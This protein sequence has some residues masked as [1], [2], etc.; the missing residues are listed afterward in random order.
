MTVRETSTEEFSEESI[1]LLSSVAVVTVVGHVATSS[2]KGTYF[3]ANCM[4][5][6]FVQAE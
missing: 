5:S 6:W 2:G 3:T 4:D 1:G